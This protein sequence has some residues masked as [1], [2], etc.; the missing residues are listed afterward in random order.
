[1]DAALEKLKSRIEKLTAQQ[2]QIEESYINA[3]AQLLKDMTQN[4]MDLPLLAGMVLNAE[5]I[6]T[7]NPAKTEAWQ[8]AGQKFLFQS[9][10]RRVPSQMGKPR[11]QNQASAKPA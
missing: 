2:R 11:T 4:G 8:T 5:G 7:E 9:K 1:M 6:L 3:V 10:N